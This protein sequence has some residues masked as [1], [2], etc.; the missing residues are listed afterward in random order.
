MVENFPL[1]AVGTKVWSGAAGLNGHPV[2]EVPIPQATAP[3]EGQE[4]WKGAGR[5]VPV[6]GWPEARFCCKAVSLLPWGDCRGRCATARSTP[7]GSA[8][9]SGVKA[10]RRGAGGAFPPGVVVRG[11][12]PEVKRH[13]FL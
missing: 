10:R 5:Y 3:R 11:S 7:L 4:D 9:C 12:Y 2:A 13:S 6:P 1:V 8:D